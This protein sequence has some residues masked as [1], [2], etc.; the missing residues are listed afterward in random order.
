MIFGTSIAILTSAYPPQER[1]RA[2]GYSSAAVYAGLSVGPLVGGFL[3]QYLGWQSIFYS[4]GI[5]GVITAVVVFTMMKGEWTGAKGEKFDFTGSTLFILGMVIL[6]YAFSVFPK[7]WGF[8]L[9]ALAI[10]GF[11]AFIIWEMRQKSPV[12]NVDLF[13]RN[14]VFAF[15]NLAALLNYCASAGSG[16]L[17]SLYLQSVQGFSPQSTPAS[18]LLSSRL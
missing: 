6:I 18:Y 11:A 14:K 1:G 8:G 7:L 15:S 2:L 16:F 3:T 9:V 4:I 13:R 12:L 10:A 5:I 17:L